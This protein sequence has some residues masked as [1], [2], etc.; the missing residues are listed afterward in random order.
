MKKFLKVSSV[1]LLFINIL[2]CAISILCIVRPEMVGNYI[3]SLYED[4]T[5]DVGHTT[6]G[7]FNKLALIS[8]ISA[9]VSLFI[10]TLVLEISCSCNCKCNCAK[11]E[12]EEVSTEPA[13]IVSKDKAKKQKKKLVI[14]FG[15][16]AKEYVEEK[17]ET[18]VKKRKQKKVRKEE[19]VIEDAPVVEEAPVTPA[20]SNAA[21]NKAEKINNFVESLKR[22]K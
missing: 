19:A 15:R 1:I 12:S 5:S 8:S 16:K 14:A 10:T 22:K 6:A 4:I 17:V 9:C 3:V 7:M 21:V 11:H 13:E 18:E 2:L 20:Q